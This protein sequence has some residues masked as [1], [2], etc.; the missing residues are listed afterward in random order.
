[1]GYVSAGANPVQ[2]KLP[3]GTV[4]AFPVA[5]L[6][7]G[8]I[9][10][11]GQITAPY[12]LLEDLVGANVPDL[13]G[14]FIRGWDNGK[15]TDS[16]RVLGSS[17]TDEFKSHSHNVQQSSTEENIGVSNYVAPSA[18]ATSF[19]VTGGIADNVNVDAV[20][21]AE[22]R[23]KNI[24]LIYIIKAFNVVDEGEVSGFVSPNKNYIINPTFGINQREFAGGSNG[25]GGYI[26]DRWRVNN[27]DILVSLPDAS[28]FVTISGALSDQGLSQRIE[29]FGYG[30]DVTLSWEGTAQAQHR[31]VSEVWQPLSDSPLTV[32]LGVGEDANGAI[33]R[34]NFSNGT[35]K[36]VK[37]EIGSVVTPFEYPDDSSELAKCHRYY[38]RITTDSTYSIFT[39]GYASSSVSVQCVL[40]YQTKRTPPTGS[41]S[42]SFRAIN[43]TSHVA[44][45]LAFDNQ[46]LDRCRL[47]LT[48]SGMGTDEI[49]G[50]SANNDTNAY[51][52]LDA[53]L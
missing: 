1:M 53:E 46:M 51:L 52:E 50:C 27:T 22:S 26:Y 40:T 14:E 19:C 39:T 2:A 49:Y 42:G 21:G 41:A 44:T 31:D 30:D 33:G 43:S 45:S 34:F 13:R 11:N 48:T 28:G 16:G 32:T 9:E 35:V 38:E 25:G 24:A 23:P 6:P 36:N 15:G 37:L 10:C 8:W 29:P 18:G 4:I 17:Q 3:I 5:T 20:G 7:M 47:L 12:P